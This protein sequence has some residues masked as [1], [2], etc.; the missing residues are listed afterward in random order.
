[1]RENF[2]SC[3]SGHNCTAAILFAYLAWAGGPV[4]EEVPLSLTG[5]SCLGSLPPSSKGLPGLATG[6]T[7]DEA[8]Y[9][10]G[11]TVIHVGSSHP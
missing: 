1:M 5:R 7:A 4:H 8:R 10:S 2:P 6:A 11:L 3:V 9:S